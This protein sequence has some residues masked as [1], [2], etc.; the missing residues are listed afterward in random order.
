MASRQ[1]GRCAWAFGFLPGQLHLKFAPPQ[2]RQ[3][4]RA[5][6]S[7]E[8]NAGPGEGV[9]QGLRHPQRVR[10]HFPTPLAYLRKLV[11]GLQGQVLSG[12]EARQSGVSAHARAG[13]SPA[14]SR[15]LPPPRS[16][17]LH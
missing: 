1:G 16:P 4:G 2:V 7:C 14:L 3:H 9:Y 8:D 15:V 12:E 5:V 13:L 6:C 11:S 17:E 10:A